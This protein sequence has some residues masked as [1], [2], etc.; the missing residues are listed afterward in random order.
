MARKRAKIAL[1]N[2]PPASAT[3]LA[4]MV[5]ELRGGDKLPVSDSAKPLRWSRRFAAS[6]KSFAPKMRLRD[7]SI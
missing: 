7:D 5:A 1:N 4:S 6:G 3:D 2:L